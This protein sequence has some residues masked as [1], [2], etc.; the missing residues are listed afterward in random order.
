MN[1]PQLLGWSKSV[2]RSKSTTIIRAVHSCCSHGCRCVMVQSWKWLL[3][4]EVWSLSLYR[5]VWPENGKGYGEWPTKNGHGDASGWRTKNYLQ[6]NLNTSQN[7]TRN[8]TTLFVGH[9]KC[10]WILLLSHWN[11]CWYE[12]LTW[13]IS[14]F[15][16]LAFLFWLDSFPSSLRK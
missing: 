15:S 3:I 8:A 6:M 9:T 5:A 10:H 14:C 1:L 16:P 11:Q 7:T 12:K 2:D 13:T 4:Q